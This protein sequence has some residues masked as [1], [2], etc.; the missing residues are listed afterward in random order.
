MTVRILRADRM[1][2]RLIS[3]LVYPLLILCSGYILGRIA[4][5]YQAPRKKIGFWVVLASWI[6]FAK[7]AL[8]WHNEIGEVW[9][10][11]PS[12]ALGATFVVFTVM[13]MM[14]A[15]LVQP[16]QRVAS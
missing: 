5:H 7:Y 3:P 9:R 8:E 10:N 15:G 14:V 2:T 1:S 11:H 16:R 4:K 6:A 12:I 13:W